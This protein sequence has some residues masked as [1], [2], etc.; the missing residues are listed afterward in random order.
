MKKF[1]YNLLEDSIAVFPADP[2]GS[3][4]LL[5]VDSNGEVTFASNFAETFPSLAEGCHV[6]FNESR[7]LEA[8][9][10]IHEP[11]N[12]GEHLEMMI[13]D[14]GDID[15][16]GQSAS[17]TPL[18]VMLRREEVEKGEIFHI[19]CKDEI[20]K[21]VVDQVLCV[22]LEDEKSDGNGTECMVRILT[23]LSVADFLEKEGSVPIPPYL[24]RAAEPLDKE[25]YNNVY[26]NAKQAGSVAAPTAGLHFT[27]SVLDRIGMTNCSFLAL[28]VGAGTFQPVL[29]EDARDHKMHGES[30]AVAVYEIKNIIKALEDNKPLIAVGTTSCRTLESLY[31]MSIKR[32]RGM[33]YTELGQDEWISLRDG[34]GSNISRIE[35][36]KL[37]VADKDEGEV[38]HGRTCLMIAPPNY[39]FQV[40]DHLV[41][42]FHAP[43][44]TLMLL[45]SAFFKDNEGE[46][47]RRIYEDAQDRGYKF[48]S[49]GDV[50]FFKRQ[51][52]T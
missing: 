48:L 7:V 21:V 25:R 46:L 16:H 33:E 44:S 29:V 32:I 5:Y 51:G 13:L 1:S 17:K 6:V 8:R 41:T 12:E 22:W 34:E 2:R 37:I 28:H 31:W 23:E 18:N 36:L 19:P 47:I 30:F 11:S 3:S 42:N 39:E 26:A 50:C 10:F 9:L 38:I 20:V 35:A 49:Y 14:L 43:D 15:L 27:P 52:L 45:V 24:Q 4:K 40:M